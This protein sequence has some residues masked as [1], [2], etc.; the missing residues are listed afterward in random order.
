MPPKGMSWADLVRKNGSSKG[1]GGAKGD[2]KGRSTESLP[3]SPEMGPDKTTAPSASNDL[4]FSRGTVGSSGAGSSETA[5]HR[6]ETERADESKGPAHWKEPGHRK[7][8]KGCAKGS[9]GKQPTNPREVRVPKTSGKGSPPSSPEP[10]EREEACAQEPE[11]AN[12]HQSAGAEESQPSSKASTPREESAHP[13]GSCSARS[14]ELLEKQE[15]EPAEPEE[16]TERAEPAA[17]AEPAERAEAAGESKTKTVLTGWAKL[18]GG[19]SAAD[20]APR[21]GSKGSSKGSKGKQPTNPREVQVPK[22]SGKGSPPSSPEPEAREEACAQEPEPANAHQSA[23]AEESQPSSKASTPREESAHPSGSCSARSSELLEKQEPEPAEPEEPTE[24]AEPAAPAEPAERAEAAGESKTK[25]VLTGWA[26]LFGGPSA[27]DPAP[28]KGSKGSSKGSKGKQ[29]TNPREV[30]VPKTS[31]KGSPPSSPEPEA[32]EEACAQEPEPAN[33][34][35][36]AGAEES[37]PSSK[38]STPREESAHPSGSC[39]ARSSELL[40][41][42]EPEPAEPEE[43]TERAEPAAPAEPAERAEAAGESKTKTVLTGWAKLF[44]GPSAADPAPRKGS[45]GSSKGSKGKQPTNPREVQVPKTSGKGSP[46][47]SPEP[48]AREEACAQEPE[49][50]NAHQSAGAEESQP[51]SK[52]A[53]QRDDSPHVSAESSSAS[54]SGPP[55]PA[56]EE[57]PRDQAVNGPAI[58]FEDGTNSAVPLTKAGRFEDG[59]GS[60]DLSDDRLELDTFDYRTYYLNDL[61]NRDSDTEPTIYGSDSESSDEGF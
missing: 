30:Q 4:Q 44:G 3:S 32:R 43:P 24:R 7:G 49:P 39:S 31:G 9:K 37:Q 45:K 36:S 14:S 22:T 47:S 42:Q 58:S 18:F 23:G 35:Q 53:S 12:A 11:P 2:A 5:M 60:E 19:P 16:P 54:S 13:S 55:E 26:K 34:H 15:P 40:E 57:G 51:S 56:K 17:P 8:N 41:K 10:Q 6:P 33:A 48:E 27:A 29:P 21:K 25:T 59:D 38:A 28:R 61:R 1:N 52:A 20:P 50:A 46:P